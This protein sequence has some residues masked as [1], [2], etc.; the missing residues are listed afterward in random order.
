MT[1]ISTPSGIPYASDYLLQK[2]NAWNE[3]EDVWF[4]E[5]IGENLDE[6]V[7]LAKDEITRI[8]KPVVNKAKTIFNNVW[9][10]MKREWNRI[11]DKFVDD[12]EAT[13]ETARNINEAL[14]SW[15]ELVLHEVTKMWKNAIKT[16]E[17]IDHAIKKWLIEWA[18][19]VYEDA[20]MKI[21][22]WWQIINFVTNKLLESGRNVLVFSAWLIQI[23][24]DTTGDIVETVY[25]KWR[26]RMRWNTDLYVN[27]DPLPNSIDKTVL[28]PKEKKYTVR[29]GDN[30]IT[31]TMREVP[32]PKL[33][34]AL[35]YIWSSKFINANPKLDDTLKPW[36]QVI[37][38]PYDIA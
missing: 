24:D 22:I 13:K 17:N 4:F 32:I 3:T 11:K 26:E 27:V 33:S 1:D 36:S 21:K 5:W 18:E 20:K 16:A 12:W 37:L 23:V 14:I 28:M 9:G 2:Q 35:N 30:L 6:Q 15:E 38:P 8:A 31:I 34:Q 7:V 10:F 29:P 19:F 25:Q